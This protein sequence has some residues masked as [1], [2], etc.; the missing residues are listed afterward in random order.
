MADLIRAAGVVVLRTVLEADGSRVER[1]LIVHRPHRSDWSLP[2]GKVDPGEHLLV[3]ALRECDEET[4]LTVTLGPKLTTASY[5]DHGTP[6]TVDYWLARERFDNG[7]IPDDEIDS[8]E[9]IDLDQLSERLTYGKDVD[10]VQSAALVPATSPFIVLRHAKAMKRADFQGSPDATRPLAGRGRGQSKQLVEL[11]D[12]FGVERIVTSPATRCLATVS[13]L[14]KQLDVPI[15]EFSELS[16]E[17][18]AHDPEAT[19][20]VIRELAQESRPTVLCSHRPVMPTVMA[21]LT[22]VLD[23][24]RGASSDVESWD[25]RLSPGE[26]VVVHRFWSDPHSPRVWSVERHQPLR[27]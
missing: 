26:F 17:G 27:S 18:H 19:A 14:A 6:K 25:A 21:S 5:L 15:E 11:L 8:I 3:T 1:T 9:W 23:V 16:E 24:P 7:F 10:L 12:A 2:K 20:A 13:R 4:G 22:N